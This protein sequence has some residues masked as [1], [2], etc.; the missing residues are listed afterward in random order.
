M[1]SVLLGSKIGLDYSDFII[2][3]IYLVVN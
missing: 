3:E 2:F 1:N